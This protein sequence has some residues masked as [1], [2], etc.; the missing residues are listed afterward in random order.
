MQTAKSRR[1]RSKGEAVRTWGSAFGALSPN[2][3]PGLMALVLA[4]CLADIKGA[5]KKPLNLKL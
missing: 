5:P 3:S 1:T 4:D 2:G